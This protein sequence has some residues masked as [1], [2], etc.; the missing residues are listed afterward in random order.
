VQSLKF[1]AALA[2]RLA[3]ATLASRLADVEGAL[4]ALATPQRFI[5]R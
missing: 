3:A 1:N 2:P 5:V 4:A